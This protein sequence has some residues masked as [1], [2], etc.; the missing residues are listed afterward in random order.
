MTERYTR[1]PPPVCSQGQRA[2]RKA[3]RARD[4]HTT[5]AGPSELSSQNCLS[6]ESQVLGEVCL[7][8]PAAIL[9]ALR[10]SGEQGYNIDAAVVQRLWGGVVI[11]P[12]Q[13]L[14]LWGLFVPSK[15]S[16]AKSLAH[17]M[18]IL[19]SVESLRR[20]PCENL[21]FHPSHVACFTYSITISQ[22]TSAASREGDSGWQQ[23]GRGV[24][25]DNSLPGGSSDTSSFPGDTQFLLCRQRSALW[26]VIRGLMIHVSPFLCYRLS[27]PDFHSFLLFA[28]QCL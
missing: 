16:R 7:S 18:A 4:W 2:E 25:S 8:V 1:L 21:N 19:P 27:S 22:M 14:T 3:Q 10:D 28:Q 17:G 9:W 11:T 20:S 24:H 6:E 15:S 12:L 23:E 13:W 26:T 5:R